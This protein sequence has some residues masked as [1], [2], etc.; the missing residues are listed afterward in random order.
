MMV[1]VPILH[2]MD[3]FLFYVPLAE[4]I[5]LIGVAIWQG[6]KKSVGI[7]TGILLGTVVQGGIWLMFLLFLGL[8]GGLGDSRENVD[9]SSKP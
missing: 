4:L 2:Y 1:R 8:L 9:Y 6:S 3:V 5:I 7:L